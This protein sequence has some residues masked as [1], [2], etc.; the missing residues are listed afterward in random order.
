LAAADFSAKPKTGPSIGCVLDAGNLTHVGAVTGFQL[1]SIFGANLGP[2][3]GVAAPKGGATSLGGVSAT[4]DGNNPA[5][6]LYVSSSQI[7]LAVP[8]PLPSREVVSWPT[9]TVMELKVSGA[10][11]SR[12][13]P[14]I[15]NN[16]SLFAN[17]QGGPGSCGGAAPG[18]Q[19]FPPVAKNAD[20]SANSCTNP[21]QAGSTVSFLMQGVG[22]IQLGFPPTE[23]ISDLTATLGFCSAQVVKAALV[24]NFVY[25]V[26]VAIPASLA[27]C[28]GITAPD[29]RYQ[30][31]AT[32]NYNGTP[33]G[34]FGVPVPQAS[35][36]FATPGQPIPMTVYLKQ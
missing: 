36:F 16:L 2:A 12:Q 23:Q 24:G 11:V 33:V 15:L 30:L 3:K 10:T 8:L 29:G 26:E 4:F 17:L 20:G 34:P 21:A 19:G 32:F 31:Q 6:L 5:Q 25:R 9:A 27:D 28:A 22:A 1:I 18:G 14:Y 13:F 35:Y 7:N